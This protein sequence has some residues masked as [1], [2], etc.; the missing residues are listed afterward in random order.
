MNN[1]EAKE[2]LKSYPH[3][4]DIEKYGYSMM[5]DKG[6]LGWI[7]GYEYDGGSEWYSWN[8][9]EFVSINGLGSPFEGKTIYYERVC[10]LANDPKN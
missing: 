3:H 10:A 7:A 9:D 4:P 8:G 2:A 6:R 5:W 1:T